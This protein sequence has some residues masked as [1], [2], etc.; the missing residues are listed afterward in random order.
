M[1]Y[2]STFTGAQIDNAVTRVTNNKF[3]DIVTSALDVTFQSGMFVNVGESKYLTKLITLDPNS[4]Y[5]VD[6]NAFI[7]PF[8]TMDAASPIVYIEGQDIGNGTGLILGASPSTGPAGNRTP[9]FAP[10]SLSLDGGYA[11][12]TEYDSERQL[13]Y[14]G[15]ARTGAAP[16][17][18]FYYYASTVDEQL[19]FNQFDVVFTKVRAPALQV[20]D[21]P[22]PLTTNP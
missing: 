11:S 13:S 8:G 22:A 21:D 16:A 18:Q 3:A 7:L 14:R 2:Q 20:I 6:I 10:G 9:I 5:I 1:A 17:C 15:F 12:S 19:T 4:Y